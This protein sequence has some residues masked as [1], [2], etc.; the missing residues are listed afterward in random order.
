MPRI[1]ERLVAD[2]TRD[3]LDRGRPFVYL[4]ADRTNPTSNSI[5]Q[6]I[7]IVASRTPTSCGWNEVAERC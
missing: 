4:Y 7:D 6:K 3:Q 1:C 2:L 5:Y